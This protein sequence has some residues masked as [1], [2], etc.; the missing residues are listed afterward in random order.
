MFAQYVDEL[1]CARS[2]P[3]ALDTET[4]SFAGGKLPWELEVRGIGFYMPDPDFH[5]FAW[6]DA[7]DVPTL[8]A[9]LDHKT[10]LM[11]NAGFDLHVLSGMGVDVS[12]VEAHDT[13]VMSHLADENCSHKLKDLAKSVLGKK[14]VMKYDDVGDRPKGGTLFADEDAK[15]LA[16]WERKMAEYCVDD[17]LYTYGL[18][19]KLRERLQDEGLWNTYE[20][21]ERPMIDIIRRIERTG[22]SV[23]AEYLKG[24]GEKV[25][26]EADIREIEIREI[27]G[28]GEFNPGS[29]LQLSEYLF[30]QKKYRLPEDF[31]TPKG[32]PSTNRE[33]LEWLVNEKGD[34]VA[35]L[36]LEHREYSKIKS[37]YVTGLLEKLRDG[38][39]H[40]RFNQTGTAT[41]RWSSSNPNMQNVP[42]RDDELDIRH[43]FMARPGHVFIINDYSQIELRLAAYFSDCPTLI[44]AYKEGKDIHQATA[45]KMGCE[46]FVS[47]SINF[48]ILYGMSA[49]GLARRMK[50][51]E[52]KAQ[53]FIDQYF[54]EFPEIRQF[55]EDCRAMVRK[56]GYVQTICGRKRRFP[57]YAKAVA[58]DDWKVIKRAERQ[59][60]N[61]VIQ[62]SAADVVKLAVKKVDSKVRRLGCSV[63]LQVHDEL[64]VEVPEDTVK[65]ALLLIQNEMENVIRLGDIPLVAEPK[66]S[67][68]WVK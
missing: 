11:H 39:L 40:G 60:T 1:V 42:R 13:L 57:D 23:D 62:G 65:T 12:R 48:G 31:V 4:E 20:I 66:V 64:L 17:C 2:G 32:K 53:A 51:T 25:D 10:L 68:R 26:R 38:T 63:L 36:T 35:Q 18:Y 43:A 34:R 15:E 59:A 55:T 56:F 8:Q 52:E 41:G 7:I 45:D 14:K 30:K 21:V 37:T 6:A 44:E 54:R 9:V 28:N 16:E 47:K 61:A 22:I 5:F 67:D 3:V 27:T 50:L 58:D 33:A 24:I 19:D 46:R 29:S 49:H